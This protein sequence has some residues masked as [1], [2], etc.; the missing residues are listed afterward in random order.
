MGSREANPVRR[1]GLR[2]SPWAGRRSPYLGKGQRATACSSD[3]SCVEA[4]PDWTRF[5]GLCLNS[6][7]QIGFEIIASGWLP[8][9][10]SPSSAGLGKMGVRFAGTEG[11]AGT[12]GNH[13]SEMYYL[14]AKTLWSLSSS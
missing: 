7:F 12:V 9:Q 11:V 13:P 5:I 3:N 1:T 2:K 6:Y 4:V 14:L 10:T 8:C